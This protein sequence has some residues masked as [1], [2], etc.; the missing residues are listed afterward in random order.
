M[1][2]TFI[3]FDRLKQSVSMEQVLERYGLRERLR[4]GGDSLSGACPLHR[5][6]WPRLFRAAIRFWQ[7]LQAFLGS[8][9]AKFRL[10]L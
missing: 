6:T 9:T 1:N 3:G 8:K 5:T 2:K 7:C 10:T 4:R